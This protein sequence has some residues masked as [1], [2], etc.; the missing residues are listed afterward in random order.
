MAEASGKVDQRRLAV[1]IH[2]IEIRLDESAAAGLRTSAFDML[3]QS[4]P[5]LSRGVAARRREP[6][7]TAGLTTTSRDSCSDKNAAIACPAS[8]Q[9]R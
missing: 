1:R 6:D 3:R 2:K 8:C 4:R 5:A 9:V 7:P